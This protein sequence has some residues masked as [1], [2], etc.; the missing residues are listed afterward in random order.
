[1]VWDHVVKARAYN[2]YR[3]TSNSTAA[4]VLLRKGL[5]PLKGS[6]TDR[7]NLYKR[8]DTSLVIVDTS[9]GLAWD[10]SQGRHVATST[11]VPQT[12]YYYWV[13]TVDSNRNLSGWSNSVLG[14]KCPKL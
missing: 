14:P 10:E 6:G 1:M 11:L 9:N 5:E 8:A 4:A 7:N 2:L 3:A 13:R 12:A